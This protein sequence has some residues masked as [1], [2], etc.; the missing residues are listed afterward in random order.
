MRPADKSVPLWG[1]CAEDQLDQQNLCQPHLRCQ[2]WGVCEAPCTE[3][4]D[5]PSVPEGT[6]RCYYDACRFPCDYAGQ[7]SKAPCPETNEAKLVC[8]F[9]EGPYSHQG[10]CSAELEP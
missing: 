5:C 9:D 6:A 3:D 1:S 4:A 2:L 8:S 10:W 7:G